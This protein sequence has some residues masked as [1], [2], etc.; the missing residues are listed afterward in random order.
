MTPSKENKELFD[1]LTKLR[2]AA[3]E[4]IQAAAYEILVKDLYFPSLTEVLDAAKKEVMAQ[5]D[6]PRETESGKFASV[7]A[8]YTARKLLIGDEEGTWKDLIKKEGD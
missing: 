1:N 7:L 5:D 8:Y 6:N 4:E 2:S 3:M